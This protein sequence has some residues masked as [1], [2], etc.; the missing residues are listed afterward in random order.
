MNEPE[1]PGRSMAEIASAPLNATNQGASGVDTGTRLTIPKPAAAPAR[2][3][4][5]STGRIPL[6]GSEQHRDRA[7]DQPEE[8]AV[9]QSRMRLDQPRERGRRA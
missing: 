3:V 7:G 9:D 6:Q 4:A 2:I 5:H 8:Q 1:I